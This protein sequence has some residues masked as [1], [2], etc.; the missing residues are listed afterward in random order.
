MDLTCKTCG[1]SI[2]DILELVEHDCDAILRAQDLSQ[3]ERATLLYIESRVVD[4]R[5]QLDPE[6]MNWEDRQNIKLFTAAGTIEVAEDE[7]EV[8]ESGAPPIRKDRVDVFTDEAWEVAKNARKMK[9]AD[10]IDHNVDLGNVPE[11]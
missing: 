2:N 6:K 7:G 9:A 3:N 8:Y 10:W 1:D 5:G 11:E 4:E